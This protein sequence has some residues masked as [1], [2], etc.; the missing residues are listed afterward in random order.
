M[1]LHSR[2]GLPASE[3]QGQVGGSDGGIQRWTKQCSLQQEVNAVA[4]W[5]LASCRDPLQLF[6]FV[7]YISDSDWWISYM[8]VANLSVT[9]CEFYIG[10]MALYGSSV[11]K[12]HKVPFCFPPEKLNILTGGRLQQLFTLIII[13][14]W[15][16]HNKTENITDK[17]SPPQHTW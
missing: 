6:V 14:F 2:V 17:T 16:W 3:W 12:Q 13:L 10:S 11:L 15:L 9:H 8:C 7:C 1:Q 5:L 4:V